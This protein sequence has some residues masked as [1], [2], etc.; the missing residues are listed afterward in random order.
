MDDLLPNGELIKRDRFDGRYPSS[1]DGVAR[2]LSAGKSQLPRAEPAIFQHF[3]GLH[4]IDE[5]PRRSF[6]HLLIFKT[7]R[8]EL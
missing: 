5:G 8:R 6:G 3:P 2:V 1:P 7:G 4:P